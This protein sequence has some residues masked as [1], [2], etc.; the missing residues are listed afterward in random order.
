[1]GTRVRILRRTRLVQLVGRPQW[2]KSTKL[3]E[4]SI[5]PFRHAR[6]GARHHLVR[7]KSAREKS[8][9]AR[10]KGKTRT[11]ARI[12]NRGP[13][14]SRRGVAVQ[15]VQQLEQ[16]HINRL[17]RPNSTRCAGAR[18]ALLKQDSP[19]LATDARVL[20]F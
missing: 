2:R 1:A 4:R 9:N 19:L 7:C 12:S 5:Q 15:R 11:A 20:S 8:R 14:E 10:G 18:R 17:E 16:F 6:S 3:A 13:A